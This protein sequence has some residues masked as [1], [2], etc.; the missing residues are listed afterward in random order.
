VSHLTDLVDA[1]F[2][3]FFSRHFVVT[4]DTELAPEQREFVSPADMQAAFSAS[5]IDNPRE[6]N[7]F[8]DYFYRTYGV[9]KIDL[10]SLK[11]D[12]CRR[13]YVGLRKAPGLAL[14]ESYRFHA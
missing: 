12:L 8:L 2:A 10:G 4:N 9:E 11:K 3:N 1:R 14:P 7:K 5:K 13:R 6:Q